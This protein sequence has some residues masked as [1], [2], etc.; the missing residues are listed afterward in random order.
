MSR[1]FNVLVA[2]QKAK[3][4]GLRLFLLRARS[5]CFRLW[6]HGLC[7]IHLALPFRS[8]L[9]YVMGGQASMSREHVY[10][11]LVW[12]RDC[13]LGITGLDGTRACVL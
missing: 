1:L 8:K 6:V 5:M 3:I 11:V 13:R 2:K 10:R 9:P 12:S 4:I 7:S